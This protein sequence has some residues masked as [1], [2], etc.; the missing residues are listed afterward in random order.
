MHLDLGFDFLKQ[1]TEKG[2]GWGNT[3][4]FLTALTGL[5]IIGMKKLMARMISHDV[6][7]TIHAAATGPV[8]QTDIASYPF[9]FLGRK[10]IT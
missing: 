7:V 10:L 5:M 1:S 3:G 2:T 9:L 6:H 8:S 4:M